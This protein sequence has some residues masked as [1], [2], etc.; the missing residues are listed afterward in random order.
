M[1]THPSRI[2][3]YQVVDII[4][5]GGMGVV[6]RARDPQ[7]D[8]LVAIKMIIG[9][10][11]GLLKRFNVEARSMA[12]LQHQNIVTIYDFGDQDGSPYLVMEYLEGMSL[13]SAIASGRDLSLANKLNIC[14]G[15]CNGLNYAH[16]RDIIH[17]DIKP[18]NVMLLHDGSVKIVDFGIARIGDTGISRTEVVG[19]LH[20]MS[21]EQFQ[22]H[23]LDR[24]T[25]IF[26]TGV[27]L[28]QLLTGVLPF[29]ST[30]EA[31][32]MYRIIHDDPAPLATYI[33]GYPPELETIVAR[34]LA[35]NRDSRY[36]SCRDFAFDLMSVL[37]KQKRS[38]VAQ[39]LRRAESA[40]QNNEWTKAEDCLRQILKI[41]SNHTQAHQIMSHVQ[42]KIRQQRTVEQIR[43]LRIQADEAF[44]A[45]RYDDAM[46]IVEQAIS[47]DQTNQD[48][49]RQRESIHAAK[50]RAARLKMALRRAE[51]AQHAGDLDEAKRAVQE[52]LEIE[53]HETSAKALLL[54]IAR[55][56]E[57]RERQLRLRKL[58][59]SAR[60]QISVRNFVDALSTLKEAEL[61]AP[62]SAELF[63]LLKVVNTAREE[64]A[65]K[66]ELERIAREIEAAM[67][68]EDHEAAIALADQG[69][70]RIPND[71]GLLKL[72][73][74]AESEQNRLRLGE[75]V[76]E[77]ALTAGGLLEAGKTLEALR[78]TENA[79]QR[80][81]GNIQLETLRGIAR[82][83][84]EANQAETRKQH[85][86][87]R[88]QELAAKDKYGDATQ[89]LEG[90]RQEFAGAKD[91]DTL[92][93]STRSAEKRAAL[94]DRACEQAQQ[95]ISKGSFDRA[96]RF[97][98][99]KTLELPDARLFDL[100]ESA[101]S[102]WRQFQAQL[103]VALE[104]SKRIFLERGSS[105]A[106]QYIGRQPDRF[107]EAGEFK[108]LAA[109]VEMRIAAESLDQDLANNAEP[110]AQIRLAEAALRKNP[111]NDEIKKR[112][113]S[114]RSRKEQIGAI[115][116]KARVLEASM[117]YAEAAAELRRSLQFHT[118]S[119]V[120]S[121]IRRLEQLEESLKPSQAVPLPHEKSEIEIGATAVLG[122]ASLE[123][124]PS[125]QT[126]LPATDSEFNVTKN[127]AA[128]RRHG[129]W[130]LVGALA[131]IVICAVLYT[132][133]RNPH[134]KESGKQPS[135]AELA[136]Q[137]ESN[138]L[139][140]GRDFEQA[141]NT[142]RTLQGM[143]GP[144]SEW[145]AKDLAIISE[146]LVNERRLMDQAKTAEDARQWDLAIQK[147][148]AVENLHGVLENSAATA[149]EEVKL[150]RSGAD[151]NQVA[152]L[153]FRRG[154]EAFNRNDYLLAEKTFDDVLRQASEN[155]SKR[156][157]AHDFA[158][159]SKHRYEQSTLFNDAEREFS[160]RHYEAAKKLASQAAEY[161]DGASDLSK[162]G[163]SLV[164]A[165]SDRVQQQIT[166]DDAIRQVAVNPG[167]AER[168][169]KKVIEWSDGDPELMKSA[170]DELTKITKNAST[171]AAADAISAAIKSGNLDGAEEKLKGLNPSDPNYQRLH[172]TLDDAIFNKKADETENAL[173]GPD[174]PARQASLKTLLT[175][176]Q[177]A[178]KLS[179]HNTRIASRYV[180][181]IGAALATPQPPAGG[182]GNLGSSISAEDKAGIQALLTR[183]ADII[184]RRR[185]KDLREVWPEIPKSQFD[186]YQSV[187][188]THKKL[189]VSIN[190]EKWE[191]HGTGFLVTCQQILAF[192]RDGKL[193]THPDS[194][195]FYVVKIQGSWRISD[196]PVS[197][198]Q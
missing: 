115:R 56:A 145:A 21:P 131:A 77:Q 2:G 183:Y 174:T 119:S 120:E 159:K 78:L 111:D 55:Q 123:T 8:R 44:L 175:Y 59:D 153:G 31:A 12:S 198:A 47:L 25:D 179:N 130:L 27:V 15:V 154:V 105:A 158:T 62:S 67:Q 184:T 66:E 19:S 99:E 135:N 138:R 109:T 163:A 113:A 102:Q 11:P 28:Y 24:R 87:Q 173:R 75:Y 149:T 72:R 197:A 37:E 157:E 127:A 126:E 186:K 65:R 90:A 29:Q 139:K 82:D 38:E 188:E 51:D 162:K 151:A 106:A 185:A 93:E 6:Y 7:L 41:E 57:E 13:E 48:L 167:A 103:Q 194:I 69:L 91:I 104:E 9:A 49:L 136:L 169:F 89:I 155:W 18:A 74:L 122:S 141:M 125:T 35:K 156:S 16:E 36:S 160:A 54:V 14:V 152:D 172:Q 187:I 181:D 171:D 17:R 124:G 43:Q 88:A 95:L 40:V 71:Q 39:W 189:S 22:S 117:K 137:V 97:L 101:R 33:Q 144:L 180:Q 64:Q 34:S 61:I 108:A 52:A 5:H 142:D 46:L 191:P 68:V 81:P 4:G 128:Y 94:V 42:A 50:A 168:A 196:I 26:S 146:L 79:L 3:K 129:S 100:L 30:G 147:Y 177:D 85:L 96:A 23:P 165:A 143:G 20:Y 32:V 110:E 176:F 190:P 98:E 58:L 107:R 92:L 70:R 114:V 193:E 192:E 86:L 1:G 133:L 182:S 112:L 60:E 10:T 134:S 53:P 132:F 118:S 161:P 164:K 80:A 166:F 178:A 140:A 121:E 84:L 195:N 83:R 63:S 116:G 148:E 45:R 76:R 170:N 73:A 150:K